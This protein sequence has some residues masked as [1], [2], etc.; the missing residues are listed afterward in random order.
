MIT[1][2]TMLATMMQAV[3]TSVANVALPHMQGTFSAGVD[4]ITWVL[5]SYLVANAVIV[6][7]TGWLGN[8]FGRRRIFILSLAVFTLASVGTGAAPTLTFCIVM[9]VLQGLSGGIIVPMSQAILLEAFPPEGRGKALSYFG[10]GVVFGPI[11]GP[12]LGGWITDRF[13]WRWIFYINLPIGILAIILALIFVIDP[14]YI[15]KPKGRVDYWSFLFILLG[16]GS[17]E[18]VLSRGERFD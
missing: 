18:V 11:I 3:D 8:F 10:I 6:P 14:P 15:K 12:I 17:L 13:G 5:T 4:E 7:M 9:R 16:L 1:F 2:A